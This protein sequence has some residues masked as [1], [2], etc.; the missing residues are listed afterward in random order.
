MLTDS[1]DLGQS[2]DW[3]RFS[4][5]HQKA[6][7]EETVGRL[8]HNIVEHDKSALNRTARRRDLPSAI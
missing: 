5:D 2:V 8:R 4:G 7:Q 6:C 1:Y 3:V